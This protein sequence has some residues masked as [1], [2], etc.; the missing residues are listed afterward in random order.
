MATYNESKHIEDCVVSLARQSYPV[1]IVIADDGSTDD[2]I[3]KAR[4]DAPTCKVLKLP[5]RGKAPALNEAASQSSG[6]ILLFL[7]GDMWVEPDYVQR[8][9]EPILRGDAI[10]TS[11]EQEYVANPE[12]P[13]ASALQR[14]HALPPRSRI[15]LTDDARRAGCKIYRAV[16]KEAFLKVGGFDNTGFSDDQTLYPKLKVPAA[17]VGEAICYHYNVETLGEVFASGTWGGKSTFLRFGARALLSYNPIYAAFQFFRYAVK[18]RSLT[19]AVFGLVYEW[20][21]F[22]GIAKMAFGSRSRGK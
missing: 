6:E 9:V 15:V 19:M 12:N 8:M 2:T 17:Y 10:G 4:K 14:L 7:D 13:W 3:E 5:H 22:V 20:G 11:H 18:Y 16:R 21:H 1:E